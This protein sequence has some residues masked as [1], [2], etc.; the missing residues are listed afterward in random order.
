V[1]YSL[2]VHWALEVADEF[3]ARGASI[4]VVD[5]RS[6]LPWD[7]EL[8]LDSVART[9]K[10]LV[11]HEATLTGGVGAEI[12]ATIAQEAFE[13]LDGPV[14]RVASLDTPVPFSEQLE[15]HVFW[16]KDRLPGIVEQL[17]NY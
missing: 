10:V 15:K 4:E 1:T 16:P 8:V 6:L 5:L 3:A 12:A 17:L 11:L 13:L 2:G 9:N 7:R 14:T